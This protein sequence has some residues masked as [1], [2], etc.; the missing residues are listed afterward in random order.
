MR[1]SGQP[2]NSRIIFDDPNLIST[3]GLAPTMATA[4]NVHPVELAEN[5]VSMPTDKGANPG[6]TVCSLAAGMAA[7]ANSIDDIALLRHGAMAKTIDKP[8]A[9]STLN[10]FLLRSSSRMCDNS[11][12]AAPLTTGLTGAGIRLQPAGRVGDIERM[13]HLVN[14]LLATWAC[15]LGR[16]RV[17]PVGVAYCLKS[18]CFLHQVFH[19]FRALCAFHGF[20]GYYG[21]H[22]SCAQ[23]TMERRC[24]LQIERGTMP[25]SRLPASSYSTPRSKTTQGV[26]SAR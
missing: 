3:A 7:R 16:H 2:A 1:K 5:H 14:G 8:Y 26:R 17:P 15:Y 25:V 9:S 10:S 13:A 23:T 12:R 6:V 22:V 21:C 18:L 24:R 19:L 11:T 4:Q 20:H